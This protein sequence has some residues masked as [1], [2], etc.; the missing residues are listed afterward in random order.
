MGRSVGAEGYSGVWTLLEAGKSLSARNEKWG[1]GDVSR[2]FGSSISRCR[3]QPLS[4][5]VLHLN[6]GRS[7][8][9]LSAIYTILVVLDICM[10]C[11]ILT[12]QNQSHRRWMFVNYYNLFLILLLILTW[13][14]KV[15]FMSSI[16][17]SISQWQIAKVYFA[18]CLS[19]YS[20]RVLRDR[21][22]SIELAVHIDLWYQYIE[23]AKYF[24]AMLW[25]SR[26]ESYLKW[27]LCLLIDW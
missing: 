17:L 18:L 1:R 2:A 5:V 10:I 19:S 20:N 16:Y 15:Y 7:L 4:K 6:L 8:V 22:S 3:I 27:I 11:S 13:S 21:I 14:W 12:K 24:E 25:E 23:S 9:S 26:R